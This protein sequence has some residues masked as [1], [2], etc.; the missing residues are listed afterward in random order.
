MLRF[1]DFSLAVIPLES[2]LSVSLWVHFLCKLYTNKIFVLK[3][4]RKKLNHLPHYIWCIAYAWPHPNVL[5]FSENHLHQVSLQTPF[6]IFKMFLY[7]KKLE[8]WRKWRINEMA[9]CL[10]QKLMFFEISDSE[11]WAKVYY[12]LDTH[13]NTHT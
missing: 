10:I 11:F 13:L 12:I 7:R 1:L 5:E 6:W 8:H 4:K 2:H 3:L 9:T